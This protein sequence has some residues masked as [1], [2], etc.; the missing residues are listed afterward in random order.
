MA[1]RKLTSTEKL[2]LKKVGRKIQRLILD[3]KGY[4]SLDAFA[5]EHHELIAKPTLYSICRGERDFRFSTINSLSQ[6]LGVSLI[7][8]I[9]D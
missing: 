2:F 7:D 1:S 9:N 6:A 5:L 4:S 3:E 8:L